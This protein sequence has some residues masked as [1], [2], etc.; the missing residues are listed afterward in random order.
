MTVVRVTSLSIVYLTQLIIVKK[1]NDYI[2]MNKQFVIYP[3]YG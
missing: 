2:I 3:I 1:F